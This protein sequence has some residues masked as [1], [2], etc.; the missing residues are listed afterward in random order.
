MIGALPDGGDLRPG[1][2]MT[3]GRRI[4]SHCAETRPIGTS[5]CAT[6]TM[7]FVRVEG[8]GVHNP[9]RANPRRH[10]RAR[11]LSFLVMG[12]NVLRLE[13]RLGWKHKE[14]ERAALFGMGLAEGV[15]LAGRVSSISTS[16]TPGPTARPP[17]RSAAQCRLHAR[18]GCAPSRERERASPATSAISATSLRMAIALSFGLMQ[19]MRLRK[20]GLCQLLRP[21]ADGSHYPG[22]VAVDIDWRF[23]P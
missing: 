9:G 10:H 4:T 19:F 7:L 15:K 13:E 5:K 17:R 22:G 12:E 8:D 11:P 3:T 20:T 23:R 18:S 1:C 14:I 21:P 16:A 6:K 2:A